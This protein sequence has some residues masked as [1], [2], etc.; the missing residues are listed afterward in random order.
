[1]SAVRTP[2]R[3]TGRDND[4]VA[5]DADADSDDRD[6]SD[7][8]A[9]QDTEGYGAG[10]LEEVITTGTRSKRPRSAADS[11]LPL[12]VFSNQDISSIGNTADITDVLKTLVPSYTTTPAT[13][14]G[15]AFVRA[16]VLRAMSPDQTLV[17]VNGKRS[18]R[19]IFSICG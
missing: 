11:P 6:T 13:G 8:S 4:T 2:C 15:S 10:I 16:T 7:D 14:D 17:L 1:M 5:E 3:G 19:S 9:E 18:Q 12:D